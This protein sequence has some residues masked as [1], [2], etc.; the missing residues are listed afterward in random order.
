MEFAKRGLPSILTPVKERPR[1]P[2]TWSEPHGRC[3][4]VFSAAVPICEL[5]IVQPATFWF[6]VFNHSHSPQTAVLYLLSQ[7]SSGEKGRGGRLNLFNI[8]P[9]SS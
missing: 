9:D 6:T 8:N 5:S 3:Q 7:F 1:P 4:D 2:L